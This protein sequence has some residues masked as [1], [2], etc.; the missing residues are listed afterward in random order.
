MGV[1]ILRDNKTLDLTDFFKTIVIH[2]LNGRKNKRRKQ[3]LNAKRNLETKTNI[4]IRDKEI[5]K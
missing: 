5:D 1:N 3:K 2:F 4:A